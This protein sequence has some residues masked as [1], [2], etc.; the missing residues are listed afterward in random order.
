MSLSKS[1]Y[2][3]GLQCVKSLWLKKYNKDVISPPD[4]FAQAIFSTGN[5]V[6]ELACD[7]FPG[8]KEVPYDST[9]FDEKIKLTQEWLDDG[10]NN[11]YEA[12]FKYDDVL[13][14]V[15]ILHKN[16]DDLFEMYEVKSSSWNSNKKLKDIQKY[17]NDASIQ[18]YVLTG[19]GMK[20]SKCSITM[21][22]SDYRCDGN[23]DINKLFIHKDVTKE[24]QEL[25][26]DIPTYLK[27]F[28][29]FLADRENEPDI[30]IG[31]HCFKPYKCDAYEY[32]WKTQNKIPEY[33]VFNIFNMGK[34]P[35]ELYRDGIV[36]IEDIPE[37]KLTTE[38]QK[39]VVDA[40]LN[41]SSI[42]NKDGINEFL[43]KLTYPIYHLD[44]E[45]YM[46]AIPEYKNQKPYQQMCFQYSL[47]IEHE[48]GTLE[49]KEF[50]G[51]EG[52]DPREEFIKQMISDIPSDGCV[53][54]YNE[55]F[56]KTRIKELARDFSQYKPQLLNILENVVDLAEPFRDKNYY[57]YTLKGKYSIKLVM[58]LMAPHMADAYKKLELVQNGGDA[59]NTFPKL[60]TDYKDEVEKYRKALLAYC[61]LDTLAM[62]EVLKSL[63]EKVMSENNWIKTLK[64][65]PIFNMSLSSK[66]LFHSNFIGW[67]LDTYPEELSIFFKDK[68]EIQNDN[69]ITNVKREKSNIDILF[70]LG[71]TLV[72]IE[73]KVKSI[74]YIEQLNKYELKQFD[75]NFTNIKYMLLTLKEPKIK[76]DNWIY[77]NYN[78]LIEYLKNMAISNQYHHFLV[79]DYIDFINIL[80]ENIV[81]CIDLEKI[82][83]SNLYDKNSEENTLIEQLTNVK[84]HDFYLKGLFEEFSYVV[85][86]KIE[87][88]YK[89]LKVYFAEN[90]KDIES[91]SLSILH[92]MT[93]SVGLME[94]KYKIK[95][96]II[97]I[98]IQGNQYRHFLECDAKIVEDKAKTLND[99]KLWFNFSNS[100]ANPN[101]IYPLNEKKD[102]NR[103]SSR[104]GTPFLYKSIK[105]NGLTNDELME[106]IIKDVKIL[107]EL[108]NIKI[109]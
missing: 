91:N 17:I 21:I 96:K 26:A 72:L 27:T 16:E 45:T 60:T 108:K 5:K 62:I 31:E 20:V 35:L 71:D 1:L 83:I 41:K 82:L 104:V 48:D 46:S 7:L 84:M 28:K 3:R 49:H 61:K 30:A 18:Y 80:Y 65:S 12:T 98:Q 97:G 70:E 103:F 94:I 57:D 87:Q 56:E 55:N 86:E 33:S 63:K 52:T 92:G 13:V 14:M 105:I 39:L 59:M 42:I 47:H 74:P 88:E 11:I 36:E 25:Q 43:N 100:N 15:D 101:E 8:G 68:L 64:K 2:T 9:T 10:L 77:I 4:E 76:S 22:D 34:K 66:E 69:I 32:C 107:I 109:S 73:N 102:F 58:P 53:L 85:Y 54:V 37:D 79:H 95:D 24:V 81:K 38:K 44:F 51:K 89:N 40:W 23:L 78:E 50:L 29:K 93:R 90:P 106:M 99:N 67:I 19:L 6:G 75:S